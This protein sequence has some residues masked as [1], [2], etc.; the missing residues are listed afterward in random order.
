MTEHTRESLI[1][2]AREL[3]SRHDG[4]LTRDDFTR[5]TGI[6]RYFIEQ[7]FPDGGWR[8]LADSAGIQPHPSAHGRF[9]N[10]DLLAEFHPVVRKT[11]KIPSLVQFKEK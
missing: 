11:G 3:A 9:S 4:P 8:E 6:S 10:E 1:E 7:Q 2:T 5:L